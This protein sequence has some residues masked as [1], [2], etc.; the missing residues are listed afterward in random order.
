MDWFHCNKCFCQD[1]ADFC[2][3]SCGH[4]F[5]R[6]CFPGDKCPVCGATC[7]S[8]RL[9]GDMKPQEKIF[10]K[11]PV[12]TTLNYLAHVAQVWGFQRA[13]TGRL[14]SFYKD[15]ASQAETALRET[16]Q[17]LTTRDRE[18]EVLRRENDELKKYLSV[19]KAS[20]SRCQGSRSS[21]PR[22]VGI[23]PPSQSGA[24]RPRSQLCSQVVSRSS[25]LESIP[26]RL[27]GAPSWAQAAGAAR[28]PAGSSI[29]ERDGGRS[30][31][32]GSEPRPRV[33]PRGL[34]APQGAGSPAPF[35]HPRPH[36]PSPFCSTATPSPASTRSLPY[37][38]SSSA[39]QTPMLGPFPMRPP[40]GEAGLSRG[41]PP[42]ALGIFTD[43]REVG[44]PR[45]SR[46]VERPRPVQAP[47]SEPG[48][49]AVARGAPKTPGCPSPKDLVSCPCPPCILSTA[50]PISPSPP[51][52]NAAS[53]PTASPWPV[54]TPLLVPAPP[55]CSSFPPCQ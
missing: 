44:T 32:S 53:P 25:S 15:R 4:L 47:W 16:R 31:P 48:P 26:Q 43:P 39:A 24:S 7:Q 29:G 22:P 20:P 52:A 28:T 46:S 37:R 35:P 45:S 12:D 40:G 33:A 27:S 2:I 18:L 30:S 1:G 10:F 14:L 6:K 9:A 11:S 51:S 5:C 13:Q 36:K 49:P 55:Q 42:S 50:Q 23:T 54:F 21:T 38:A 17:K 34:P 8:R 3:T 19:L 41:A